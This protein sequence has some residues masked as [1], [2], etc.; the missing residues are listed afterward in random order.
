MG[1]TVF[2]FINSFICPF[3]IPNKYKFDFLVFQIAFTKK[4][5]NLSRSHCTYILKFWAL[6]NFDFLN[7]LTKYKVMLKKQINITILLNFKC[8]K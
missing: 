8:K 4:F 3:I 7:Y 5:I 2:I 1:V 6:I